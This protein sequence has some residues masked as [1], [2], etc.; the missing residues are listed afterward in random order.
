MCRL[1]KPL[2]PVLRPKGMGLGA[3]RSKAKQTQ[4]VKGETDGS[5]VQLDFR[6]G[7][8]C[9][10]TNGKHKDSYGTVSINHQD[11]AINTIACKS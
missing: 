10:I 3:D 11:L 8:H 4:D 5:T 7:V 2:N 6:K 9:L 1:V